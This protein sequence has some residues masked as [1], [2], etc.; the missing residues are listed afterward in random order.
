MSREDFRKGECS[1]EILDLYTWEESEKGK[2]KFYK[3]RLWVGFFTG[4]IW[5]CHRDFTDSCKLL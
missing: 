3:R 1:A 4:R 5:P 2:S